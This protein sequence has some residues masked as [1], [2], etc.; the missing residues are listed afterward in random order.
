MEADSIAAEV[1][2]S[3]CVTQ[4]HFL[5]ALGGTNPSALCEVGLLEVPDT[6]WEDIGGLVRA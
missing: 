1:L 4:E 6:T 5:T 3:L 2:D